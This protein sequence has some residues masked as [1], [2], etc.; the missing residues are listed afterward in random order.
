MD[1][2]WHGEHPEP[3]DVRTSSWKGVQRFGATA[4]AC[5]KGP[6]LNDNVS[7]EAAVSQ[8]YMTIKLRRKAAANWDCVG[9]HGRM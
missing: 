3:E 8:S 6:V 2:M 7:V 9:W 4:Q 1:R 5:C